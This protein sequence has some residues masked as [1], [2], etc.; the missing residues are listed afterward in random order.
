MSTIINVECN[1]Q[2]LIIANAPIIASGGVDE[3]IV[4][5]KFCGN[6]DGF[7]KT[8]VFYQDEKKVY[9][10]FLDEENKCVVPHEVT[11]SHGTLYIGV[12]GVKGDVRRTSKVERIRIT[13]GAWSSDM[14]PSDP[15]P[16]IY[17]QIIS[18]YDDYDARL[19]Y[20]EEKFNGSVGDAE[21]LGGETASAWQNKLNAIQTTSSGTLSEAGWYRVAEYKDSNEANI[22]GSQGNSCE[23]TIKRNAIY[24]D[25]EYHKLRLMALQGDIK[26]TDIEHKSNTQTITKMRY[27][28]DKTNLIAYIEIYYNFSN[29]NG[30]IFEINS[31]MSPSGK[32][33]QAI[34]P[35]LTS[36][37]V[38]GVTVTTT[39]DI[40]ANASPV[41]DLD[42]ASVKKQINLGELHILES[43]LDTLTTTYNISPHW[44]YIATIRPKEAESYLFAGL[45]FT[46]IGMEY[47][48]CGYQFAVGMD[49]IKIREIVNGTWGEWKQIATTAD[50]ANYLP[51]TGGTLTNSLFIQNANGAIILENTSGN[52][53]VSLFLNED[54]GAAGIWR[55]AEGS[56]IEGSVL[57]IPLDGRSAP[58]F[59]GTATGNVP[60]DGDSTISGVTDIPIRLSSA[61]DKAMLGLNPQG[62]FVGAIGASSNG[63]LIH[64][65]PNKGF[66][67]ILDVSNFSDY[68]LAK[69][70]GGTVEIN[71]HD[72]LQVKRNSTDD[73][74]TSAIFFANNNKIFGGLGYCDNV[75]SAVT[76]SGTVEG[77]L[78]HTGNSSPIVVSTTAPSD[79]NAVWVVP[80]S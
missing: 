23:I 20:F 57:D 74:A 26:F 13:K 35:T 80:N 50:L 45:S 46:V 53:V 40:P 66:Y 30:C 21:K 71:S 68:A 49:D 77:K 44:T 33:W 14:H 79:T 55:Y 41:T 62:V 52:K 17:N 67:Q 75:L 61:S 8:A 28:I 12:F 5:F 29:V 69:D 16:D 51:N 65:I 36:E 78:L 72:G 19:E 34:T 22:S 43:D 42:L 48:G 6:W 15:T 70:G 37:T 76:P 9:Y 39:Y 3:N 54:V 73:T 24:A 4:Y 56:S 38:D 27:A 1:D 60:L 32:Q 11:Q 10:A 47:Y 7:D 2:D 59:N 31:L 64:Y 25:N 18:R 63:E 58:T